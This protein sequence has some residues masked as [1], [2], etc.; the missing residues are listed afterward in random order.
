[1]RRK[2]E[3]PTEADSPTCALD[4]VIMGNYFVAAIIGGLKNV[5]R[6]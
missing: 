1:M 2:K 4:V 3:A 5:A 6:T